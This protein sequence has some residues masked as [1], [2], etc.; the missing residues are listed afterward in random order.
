MKNDLIVNLTVQPDWIDYNG[1]MGDFA[2]TIAFNRGIDKLL[3]S[4]GIGKIYRT[5]S[6]STIYTLESHLVFYKEL[7]SNDKISLD[8][9]LIDYDHKRIHSALSIYDASG[10]KC[11]AYEALYM[12]IDTSSTPKGKAFP[13]T[14]VDALKALLSRHNSLPRPT[15]LSKTI[16]IRH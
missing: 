7:H 15:D 10:L 4:I 3:E 12:H 8:V 16:S 13:E 1:H 2:Y 9:Q 11:A 5:T 6:N 14:T